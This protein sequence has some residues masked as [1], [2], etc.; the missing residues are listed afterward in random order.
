MKRLT[1]H[2]SCMCMSSLLRKLSEEEAPVAA[3]EQEQTL[4]RFLREIERSLVFGICRNP[5]ATE[6]FR[7]HRRRLDDYFAAAKN[8]LQLLEH[9]AV[10][11]GDLHSRAESLLVTAMRSLATELCHLRIWMPDALA[12]YLGCTPASIWELA[13][14]SCCGSGSSSSASGASWMCTSCSSSGGSSGASDASFDG[15]FMKLGEERSVQSGPSSSSF[16]NLKSVSTFNKIAGFMIEVG[17]ERMLLGAFDQHREHLVRYIGILDIDNILGNHVVEESTGLR[18]KVWTSTLQIVFIALDEMRRQL[19]QDYGAFTSLKEDY[20]L[21]SAKVV[22]SNAP[23]CRDSNAAVK[24][25]PSKIVNVVTMYQALEYAKLEV[26]DLFSGQTKDLILADIE[27]LTNGL[28]ALFLQLLVDINDLLRSQ[29]LV[30]SNTGVH[31]VTRHVMD[32]VRLLVEQKNTVHMML[33]GNS[34]KFGQVVTQLISSLEFWLDKNS[35]S[36]LLQGQQ[37]VF[38]LNNMN[39]MLEQTWKVTD[40]VIRQKL[41]VEIV[42][43]VIPL[44]RIYLESYSEYYKQKSVRYNVEHLEAGLMEMFEG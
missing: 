42:Q 12:R 16:I 21:A 31:R 37:H 43:N 4:R 34:H 3:R 11:S 23:F 30:I 32:L 5:E 38:H 40:P 17:Y 35:R 22:P 18:L 2:A 7:D 26:L 36:L 9:P 24:H 15:C 10:A 28:S 29:D 19:N 27:R 1:A 25:D 20:L 33:N 8:L 13:R 6:F 41:R 14:S 44:Y 39:F